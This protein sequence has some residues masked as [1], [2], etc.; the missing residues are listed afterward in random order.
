MLLFT[1]QE[2]HRRS[3][4]FVTFKWQSSRGVFFMDYLTSLNMQRVTRE[5]LI[6]EGA[7][8][9][10]SDQQ[11]IFALPVAITR[12]LYIALKPSEQLEKIGQAFDARLDDMIYMCDSAIKGVHEIYGENT[13]PLK[14]DFSMGL[15]LDK[16]GATA[17][18][19][20]LQVSIAPGDDGK[21]VMTIGF[22][23]EM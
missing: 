21:P 14:A 23:H 3:I 12:S 10:I 8:I 9:D 1:K 20:H 2:Q 19:L 4:S 11:A 13:Y 22:P 15:W 7:L 5:Q 6:R 18:T 16:D 17:S